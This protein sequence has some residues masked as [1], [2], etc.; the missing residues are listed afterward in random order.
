MKIDVFRRFS[1]MKCRNLFTGLSGQPADVSFRSGLLLLR[2]WTLWATRSVVHKSAAMGDGAEYDR[3]IRDQ[4]RL[5][6]PA[7]AEDRAAARHGRPGKASRL[8]AAPGLRCRPAGWP[9]NRCLLS[10]SHGP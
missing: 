2:P 8:D 10:R 7:R 4:A 5:R 6:E 1:R 3:T 9:R